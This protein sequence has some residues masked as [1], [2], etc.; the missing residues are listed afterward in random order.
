MVIKI[1]KTALNFLS[2]TA[3]I[4]IALLFIFAAYS[5]MVSPEKSMIL[6]YMGLLFPIF[7]FLNFLFLFYWIFL[8]R[9]KYLLVGLFT[10]LICW[11]PIKSYIPIHSRTEVVPTEN[12]IKVLTYNVMGF[13]YKNHTKE[14]PNQIIKYIAESDAD[15]VCLQ[16]YLVSNS[17][18]HLSESKIRAAL[19]MYPYSNTFFVNKNAKYK[20]GIA[21]YSKYPIVGSRKVKYDSENN[22][23]T[24]HEVRVN[25]KK[26]LLINNHLESF[27]LTTEDK[28]NYS[29]FITNPG[30]ESFDGLKGAFQ[31]KLGPAFLIRA[32]QARAIKEEIDNAD[33]GAYVLVCGDFNDTPI[34]YAHRTILGDLLDAFAESGRGFGSTYNQN[35]FWFRI[36][37]IF[38]SPNMKSFNCTVDKVGYS[39]H[40]PV[41]CYLQ[42]S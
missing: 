39:D 19:K 34:S 33:D 25:D 1:L 30:A 13:A 26:I 3:N 28:S 35:F 7:G 16:E 32:K 14:A 24:V 22:G 15:I 41:W 27:K 21:V 6:S 40:Y 4:I 36:D 38:H 5:D 12:T 2:L 42:M 29:D 18:Q 37:K 17:E 8:S 9:W 20:S 10:I 31:Q 23:S 11:G